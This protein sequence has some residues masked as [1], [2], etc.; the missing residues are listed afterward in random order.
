MINL[1]RKIK[2]I[3]TKILAGSII[4]VVLTSI[5][6]GGLGIWIARDV[7][8]AT[9][10]TMLLETATLVAGDVEANAEIQGTFAKEVASSSIITGDASV[11]EKLAFVNKKAKERADKGYLMGGILDKNGKDLAGAA[12]AAGYDFF[13]AAMDGDTFI[14]APYVYDGGSQAFVVVS[15]PIM[16]GN[17]ITGVV[18]FQVS[19]DMLQDIITDV[20]IGDSENADT[21]IIASDGVTVAS[22]EYDLVLAQ[23]NLTEQAAAGEITDKG[24]LELAEIEKKMV[25]GE[26]GVDTYKSSE[27]VNYLAAYAQVPTEGWSVNVTADMDEFLRPATVAGI[28]VAI[29]ALVMIAVGYVLARILSSAIAKPII[30]CS[31]RIDLLA[32]GDITTPAPKVSGRDETKLLADST[33]SLVNGLSMIVE[34]V[35]NTLSSIADGNLTLEVSSNEY[36]GDF[37]AIKDNMLIIDEKLNNTMSQ[38]G[39]A[40]DQVFTGAQQVSAGAQ[41]LA[42]GATQQASAV[43]EVAATVNEVSDGVAQTAQNANAAKTQSD[44]SEQKLTECSESMK[45]MVEAMN[46]INEKSVEIGKIIKVIEDI[47]FQTN[48]LAQNAAV[49]AARAGEAGKGF[50][51]VADEV[52]NLAGKSAEASND[53][54]ALI[55]ASTKSVSEGMKILTVTAQTL[56]EVVE[57]SVK[58][59][60]FVNEIAADAEN[61]SNAISQIREAVEQISSVVQTTS[62][63]SQES[64][65]ISEELSSQSQILK[66]MVEQFQLKGMEQET[67]QTWIADEP[68]AEISYEPAEEKTYKPAEEKIYKPAAEK[69]HKPDAVKVKKSVQ[70][71]QYSPV[72]DDSKY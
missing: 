31:E 16:K 43:E 29:A 34:E 52:R 21:Y 59:A 62:A 41:S 56:E 67:P 14:S 33:E 23:E 7:T 8:T 6:L 65:A 10:E 18:Y 44:L 66:T 63:T 57:Y 25:A 35:D 70:D 60:E 1:F 24:D 20:K 53:T 64:A 51:E 27:G 5:I 40:T 37:A 47:A 58:S 45:H 28:A 61:Q 49:E 36:P 9:M 12:P 50:A 68:A 22:A 46:D 30:D 54:S 19:T 11:E 38:I 55:E 26:T 2:S 13:E 39:L 71:Y 72:M 15:A 32:K 17:S 3:R 48:I 4:L 69:A 42:Q